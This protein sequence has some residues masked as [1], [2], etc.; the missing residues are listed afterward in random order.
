MFDDERFTKH[1]KTSNELLFY[2]N[3]DKLPEALRRFVPRPICVDQKRGDITMC[4]LLYG[5]EN[6][7]IADFKLGKYPFGRNLCEERYQKR[8]KKAKDTTSFE[9]GFRFT[10]MAVHTERA[11]L[12]IDKSAG[13][14]TTYEETRA[15]VGDVLCGAGRDRDKVRDSIFAVTE[16]LSR[17][18]DALGASVVAPQGSSV[19]LLFDLEE[20]DRSFARMID[21]TY[22]YESDGRQYQLD[23]QRYTLE[24]IDNL[25]KFLE[26]TVCE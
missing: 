8:I 16:Q 23:D 13:R 25:K 21:F 7:V 10:G 9:F 4:N 6:Y 18:R 17:L 26:E 11:R 15:L 5:Y 3:Y 1:C 20:P 19:L 12:Q 14:Y 24:G 2:E 22:A